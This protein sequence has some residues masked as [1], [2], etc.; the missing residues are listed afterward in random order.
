[1]KV[2]LFS[3]V[4]SSKYTKRN[5]KCQLFSKHGQI[6]SKASTFS[7]VSSDTIQSF[8]AVIFILQ[9]HF[10]TYCVILDTEV[11]N[12]LGASKRA[13]ECQFMDV[14]HTD[15]SII[16]SFH[17][18]N[19]SSEARITSSTQSSNSSNASQAKKKLHFDT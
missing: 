2:N 9:S 16:L 13:L 1:M 15:S 6:L 19:R 7:T 4:L 17:L 11:C 18:D 5:K 3:L 14:I 8:V 12:A 10:K